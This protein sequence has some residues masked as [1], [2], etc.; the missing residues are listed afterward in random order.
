MAHNAA[1]QVWTY[2]HGEWFEG[3][4]QIL[5]PRHQA[6]WLAS[7]VFDGA[8]YMFGKAPD[9]DRHIERLMKSARTLGM[10]PC[11]TAEEIEAIAW[12]GI[13]KFDDEEALY[14]CP[15]RA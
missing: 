5:A 14:I 7:S 3:D 13:G 9:L 12:E 6:F 15:V 4:K 2:A 1:G 10:H 8:R 11:K